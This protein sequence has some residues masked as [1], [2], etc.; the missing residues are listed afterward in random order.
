MI[1]EQGAEIE[2]A[3]R[4]FLNGFPKAGL[5]MALLMAMSIASEP[6]FVPGWVGNF[7]HNSWSTN[8]GPLVH[9]MGRLRCIRDDTWLRGHMGYEPTVEQYLFW[10]GVAHAFI[11]RDLR[12]VLVSQSYHVI[13]EGDERFIHPGKELYR[14][15]DREARLMAC[16]CGVEEYAG[17]FERWELYAPWLAIPWVHKIR[18]EDMVDHPE[19]VARAFLQYVRARMLW[20]F[21][22]QPVD[23]ETEDQM[24]AMLVRNMQLKPEGGTFR[25]GGHGGWREE[26]TPL[27]KEEFKRRAGDWLVRLGYEEDDSW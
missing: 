15:M 17:L 7:T 1:E 12:D 5:H 3:P 13:T 25:K 10:H 16:L 18:Y 20:G 14:G 21:E 22:D 4:I 23:Q 19:Q 11:Y 2:R 8:W 24:V 27:V 26:F 9:V 6:A